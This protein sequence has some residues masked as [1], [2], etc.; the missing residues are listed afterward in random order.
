MPFNNAQ[1]SILKTLGV[2]KVHCFKWHH[3]CVLVFV[4]WKKGVG[5]AF[6][7]MGS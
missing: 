3:L 5:V 6:R 4:S 1:R 2:I 7:G